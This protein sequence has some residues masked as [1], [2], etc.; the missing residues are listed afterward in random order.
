PSINALSGG[1]FRV[2]E[3][4]SATYSMPLSLPAGIAG[5]KPELAFSYSSN[6]GDGYMGAGWGFAGAS[7]ISRCPKNLAV[8][9]VQGNVSFSASDRLCLNGQ[10][11]VRNGSSNDK[12]VTDAIYWSL[13]SQ[14]HTELDSFNLIRQHGAAGQGPRALTVETRS[15]EIHYYGA[16]TAVTGNDSTG[17]SLALIA[18][19]YGNVPENG[20]DAFFDT[21]AGSNIA[22]LWALKAIKD[23]KGNYILFKYAEDQVLGEHYLTEVH[24]TGRANGAAPFAKVVLNYVDN[25][26]IAVGWQAQKRVAMSKLLNTVD[27]LLDG[28]IYRQYRLNYFNSNVLEEKNYLLS[29]QECADTGAGNCLPPTH[30]EWNRPPTVNVSYVTRC[31]NEPGVPQ[32]CWQEPVTD[33]Y[34]PFEISYQIKGTS[35]D[36]YYQQ[37]MDIN[38]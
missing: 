31:D 22:R 35:F 36:R 9:T 27:V 28:A 30:F 34:V 18:K 10:R 17:R 6:S 4:G 13:S 8:D 16:L 29:I 24:Y 26:K 20:E 19:S 14:F 3:S 37:L 5:V 15:G 38:G 7:A 12:A 32:Y 1:E 11:L 21:S 25:T 2:D 23:V 33:N